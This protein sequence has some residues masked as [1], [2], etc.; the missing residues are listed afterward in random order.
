ME[1]VQQLC[2]Q[3]VRQEY[4]HLPLRNEVK[5]ILRLLPTP[6]KSLQYLFLT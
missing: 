2:G 6:L 1:E 3:Q 5:N 4:S